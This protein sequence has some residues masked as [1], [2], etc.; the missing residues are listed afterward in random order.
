MTDQSLQGTVAVVT[1]A[2]SAMGAAVAA[3]LAGRGAAVVLQYLA[4]FNRAKEVVRGIES[5]GGTAIAVRADLQDRAQTEALG[6]KAEGA[7]GEVD[8]VVVTDPAPDAAEVHA[9]HTDGAVHQAADQAALRGRLLAGL[10]PLHQAAPAMAARRR[11]VLVYLAGDG[12]GQEQDRLTRTAVETSVELLGRAL[13]AGV[14]TRYLEGG[15]S[16]CVRL[17]EEL[18]GSGSA[19]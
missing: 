3:E 7:I 12:A 16:D 13:P 10:A 8:F 2:E 4:S 6:F 18:A 14:H 5:A 19:A 9:D 17:I 15:P 1:G 11:G